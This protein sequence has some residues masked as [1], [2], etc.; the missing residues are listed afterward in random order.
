MRVFRFYTVVHA[1]ALLLGLIPLLGACGA[2]SAAAGAERVDSAGVVLVTN[3]GEDRPLRW[4]FEPE[5]TL[6]GDDFYQVG[7]WSVGVD[8]RGVIHVL[9]TEA[10]RVLRY[11][12]D[13][14]PLTALGGPGEGPGEME[15][16]FMLDVHPDGRV[17]VLDFGRGRLIT[18]APDGSLLG[19]E[20][21]AD[22]A[23]VFRRVP[24]GVVREEDE[25]GEESVSRLLH[26]SAAGDT[27]E[28]AA[29]DWTG[30]P[31]TLE[32]CG[33]RFSGMPPVFTPTLR[34]S[35]SGD[36]I[37]V[38]AGPAYDI[39]VSDGATPGL[40]VRRRLT[41]PAATEALG[42]AEIG[43]GMTVVT[44]GGPRVC[45]SAEVVEQR[46][47]ADVVP[48]IDNVMVDPGGRLWVRRSGGGE[49]GPIDVFRADGEYLGTLPPGAPMP[50][51]FAP[52]GRAL[53][54]ETD[55]MDVERLVIGRYQETTIA[56]G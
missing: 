8:G 12:S 30:R 37:A 52:D 14:S 2:G 53:T 20:A 7:R 51:G 27:T 16:P 25:Y 55:E 43:D 29:I 13:G 4:R 31:I 49:P 18:W 19:E 5:L 35:V 38:A 1:S 9:D 33:M 46:G 41:P 17:G 3:T 56:E 36:R 47:L 39:R 48:L 22:G 34:W 23:N 28:L 42:I 44:S 11:A 6:G 10:K 24:G 15:W 26:V 32:S 45:D 21:A 50:I 40:R 54:V